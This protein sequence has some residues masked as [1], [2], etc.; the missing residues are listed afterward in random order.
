M[1]VLRYGIAPPSSSNPA[2]GLYTF[3]Y[4]SSCTYSL[5]G[6]SS[7]GSAQINDPKM[8]INTTTRLSFERILTS[9]MHLDSP[10]DVVLNFIYTSS[11]P[12]LGLLLLDDDYDEDALHCVYFN[13]V[14]PFPSLHSFTRS[15]SLYPLLDGDCTFT[16]YSSSCSSTTAV[17]MV[18]T[19]TK[20]KTIGHFSVKLGVI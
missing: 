14:F 13:R 10:V 11:T 12:P 9:R 17:V 6:M 20:H 2:K 8:T 19:A 4:K 15:S 16:Q 1:H 5:W 18:V 3:N 7:S